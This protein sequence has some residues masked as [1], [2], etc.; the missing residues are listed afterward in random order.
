MSDW[1][2]QL[3]GFKEKQIPYDQ[4]RDNFIYDF[5]TGI[6]T[7]LPNK[8][9]Y[10]AGRFTNPS[11]SALRSEYP[12]DSDHIKKAIPGSIKLT[13]IISDVTALHLKPENKFA[14]FQAASQFN[15]LEFTSSTGKP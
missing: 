7:S 10:L 14:V 8:K 5:N 4:I 3:F 1:F 11:L 6:L 15:C 13:E 12:L 9:Q 2:E